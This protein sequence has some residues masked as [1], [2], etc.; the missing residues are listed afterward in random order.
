MMK[1]INLDNKRTVDIVDIKVV[2]DIVYFTP[3]IPINWY[4][5]WL[6]HPN[7]IYNTK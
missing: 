5:L 6:E 3:T 7:A 1:N 2:S 4:W